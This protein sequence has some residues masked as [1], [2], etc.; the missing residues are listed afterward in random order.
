MKLDELNKAIQDLQVRIEH[1]EKV[2]QGA[3]YMLSK[4]S[5]QKQ[6]QEIVNHKI[7]E[8]EN[9]LEYLYE[10][11]HDYQ[12]KRQELYQIEVDEDIKRFGQKRSQSAAQLSE[13]DKPSTKFGFMRADKAL[14]KEKA[15]YLHQLAVYHVGVESNQRTALMQILEENKRSNN[16]KEIDRISVMLKETSAR[17]FILQRSIAYYEQLDLVK[18]SFSFEKSK[19]IKFS[20]KLS[21]QVLKMEG[22]TGKR[23]EN[24]ELYIKI[25]INGHDKMMTRP[26]RTNWNDELACQVE[27]SNHVEIAIFEEGSGMIAMTFFSIEDFLHECNSQI[28]SMLQASGEINCK[29]L[30]L[31]AGSIQVAIKYQPKKAKQYTNA[32]VRRAQVQKQ[33]VKQR[34][35]FEVTQ[36]RMLKCA[37]CHEFILS[38][39]LSCNY[40]AMSCH[41]TCLDNIGSPQQC[42]KAASNDT[43]DSNDLVV[44]HKIPHRF[45]R[46]T[47]MAVSWCVHCGKMLPIG[48]NSH[49]ACTECHV[50]CHIDC[51]GFVPDYC[52]LPPAL[53][54]ELRSFTEM[55]EKSSQNETSKEM[56]SITTSKLKP[57]DST[58][59][60][61]QP[62][63]SRQESLNYFRHGSKGVG[64]DDFTFLA[65]L[66]KGNFGKVMLAQEKFTN[67]HYAIK[68]LKKEF[69]LEHDEVES[70][71]SEKNCFQIATQTMHPFLVH[72]HS[73]FQTES[74]LYF[75]MEYVSGGDLMYH[76][77]QRKFN[78]VQAKFYACEVLLALEYWHQNNILYRDLKLDNI[79][80]ST[81]GHVKIADYGL[82]KSGMAHGVVTN[83]FCGTPEFM[84]P[85][86]LSEQP[87]TRAVDWWSFGVLIYEMLLGKV[88][89]INVGSLRW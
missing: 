73:C 41:R 87:Y 83:T 56:K 23:S 21:L 85:E 1:E 7:K 42:T 71:R 82:C 18:K 50:S 81:D 88:S 58:M 62:K 52:G 75:V 30:L 61:E 80:L 25:R 2:K 3:E 47:S 76:I 66:G 34:H 78:A 63:K 65:V 68:V 53:L 77:Q 35:R 27:H 26:S 8:A 43:R 72:L 36:S 11:I 64:L 37:V 9:R 5:S 48:R 69:I 12:K 84:A 22:L 45:R 31:P 20:G 79:L 15:H 39:A 70:T 28:N 17:L 55:R 24:S 29:L 32:L 67:H 54:S 38:N 14:T 40:C 6:Q 89:I 49:L 16:T 33:F 19:E 59:I 74:R 60:I 10:E 57:S 51:E 44:K 4:L 46:T 13:L 86:I